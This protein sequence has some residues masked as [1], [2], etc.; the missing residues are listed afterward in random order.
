[1]K[2][3]A[4]TWKKGIKNSTHTGVMKMFCLLLITVVLVTVLVQASFSRLMMDTLTELNVTFAAN[5]KANT[6]TINAILLNYS[7]SI[8]FSNEVQN[9]RSDT[10]PGNLKVIQ[11]VRAMNNMTAV[12]SFVESVYLYNASYRYVYS[13]SDLL[14]TN[15]TLERF[16]DRTAALIF[17][18]LEHYP[19]LTPFFRATEYG[20]PRGNKYVYSYLIVSQNQGSAM[21]INLSSEW[22]N[23]LILGND[24]H[25][26]LLDADGKILASQIEIGEAERSAVQKALDARET[27]SGYFLYSFPGSVQRVCFFA[28]MGAVGWRYLR[29]MNYDDCIG[30]QKKVQRIAYG[31]IIAV[32]ITAFLLALI[33][34]LRVVFP[35]QKLNTVM[36]D[37]GLTPSGSSHMEEL[38]E[39]LN[40]LINLS[41]R[42]EHIETAFNDMLRNETLYNVLTGAVEA[43]EGL[44]Q[45]SLKVDFYCPVMLFYINGVNIK[46]YMEA[47]P[48]SI[49]GT[50]G[51]NV[52][53][54][55]SVLLVQ[56]GD[57]LS[58][59][60]IAETL[61][62][63]RPGGLVIYGEIT[64]HPD[65]L[66]RAYRHLVRM[67]N[68]RCFYPGQR[69]LNTETLSQL[70]DDTQDLN[71]TTHKL[72]S[73]L[74]SGNSTAEKEQMQKMLDLLADKKYHTAIAHLISV[75]RAMLT[76]QKEICPQANDDID[77][78]AAVFEALLTDPDSLDEVRK[79]LD[80]LAHSL[81]SSARQI[82]K[83]QH[84]TLMQ[85][86]TDYINAAYADPNLNSQMLA[87]HFHISTAYLC[88]VFR[89]GNNQSLAAYITRIRI[90]KACEMLRTT[91]EPIK[92]ISCAVGLDNSQYFYVQFK[93]QMDMT[94]NE[95]REQSKANS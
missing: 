64:S 6:D 74:K 60:A 88:R 48:S 11:G 45:F 15:D 56:A 70:T 12:Y 29:L 39:K 91:D 89:K 46:R 65:Q 83:I 4:T 76:L 94:P 47:L 44:K 73:A 78:Q 32:L 17:Q 14:G 18:N 95:F 80:D 23:E 72:I 77:Q 10:S 92:S 13:T 51:I 34:L 36:T 38:T 62:S 52:S 5:A 55:H 33:L 22:L 69:L 50:E 2:L 49:Q 19:K 27:D 81:V 82:K 35:F 68:R 79:V 63:S 28:D 31:F 59:R 86:I 21:M 40:R 42:A 16:G 58:S 54:R 84:E 53:G 41:N 9:L 26:C 66:Q 75:Y 30:G 85:Q 57:D 87:D 93:Q 71:A 61:L 90:K 3:S 24:Q 1:M 43:E 37:A 20:S 25:A 8:Y 7:L 67:Y